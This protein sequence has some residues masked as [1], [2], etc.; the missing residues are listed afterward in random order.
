MTVASVI[1]VIDQVHWM[2]TKLGRQC[3]PEC[4]AS[5]EDD[6]VPL[7]RTIEKAVAVVESASHNGHGNTA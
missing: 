6:Q 1:P 7:R 2:I 5:S 4:F 3:V